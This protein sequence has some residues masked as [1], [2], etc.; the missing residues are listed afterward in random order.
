M[1]FKELFET[2]A[3][4]NFNLYVED[5]ITPLDIDTFIKDIIHCTDIWAEKDNWS[6]CIESL[7]LNL[8]KIQT[9]VEN[10]E[11]LTL[12]DREQIRSIKRYLMSNSGKSSGYYLYRKKFTEEVIGEY[13]AITISNR[14]IML[15]NMDSIIQHTNKLIKFFE[16]KLIEHQQIALINQQQDKNRWARSY[17]TCECG[18]SVQKAVR[19]RHERSKFHLNYISKKNVI[20]KENE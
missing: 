3:L 16:D 4:K 7:I 19:S 17:F 18:V 2:E 13:Y 20:S 9:M 6:K 14:M 11:T 1:N 10:P 5:Y 8:D 12:E 15:T